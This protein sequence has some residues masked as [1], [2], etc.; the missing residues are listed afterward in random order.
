MYRWVLLCIAFLLS[1]EFAQARMRHFDFQ[2]RQSIVNPDC[3]NQSYSVPTIN[4]EFPAPVIRVVQEDVV[5]IAITNNAA[6]ATSVHFHG[7]RQYG[8]PEADG[9]ADITQLAIQP[10]Q[11]YVHRFQIRNQVG[12]YFYH[13]H[14]GL[15]DESIQGPFIVYENEESLLKAAGVHSGG[16]G[17]HRAISP[18]VSD[19]PFRYHEERILQW[20]EWWHQ[21]IEERYNYYMGKDY[22]FE[23]QADSF[24]LNGKSV[25]SNTS[26]ID[27]TCNG[28]E[29]IDVEPNKIYRLRFIGALTHRTLGIVIQNHP[30]TLIEIDGEYVQPKDID[31]VELSPGQRMSVLIKTENYPQGTI[32]PISSNIRWNDRNRGYTT[33]G[34]GY[35]R[36]GRRDQQRLFEA[37]PAELLPKVF[38]EKDI[39]G[40][41]LSQVSPLFQGDERI[42]NG[43]AA[44]TLKIAMQ[45]VVEEG[46]L[47][48]FR[49]NGRK[50]I[51][52]GTPTMSLFDIVT[53]HPLSSQSR[54][55]ADGFS[56]NHQTYPVGPL[57]IVD[58]VFQNMK[59]KDNGLCL[60]HP[61]HTHGHS[62]YLLAEGD[63]DY[64]HDTHKDV[65]TF[66]NPL[67]KDV[68]NVYPRD[69][70][71]ST[72]GCGWT[73]VRIFTVR[74]YISIFI[75]WQC[76]TFF[77][78]FLS[79]FLL[80]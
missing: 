74:I 26:V 70:G 31:Y 43:K 48:R 23:Q 5:E 6:S 57:E 56:I 4:G 36:Y 27:D 68:S 62:H 12:T 71:N 46:N 11:S 17:I 51:P 9:V 64:N 7:I 76:L 47:T 25:F 39:P 61:W 37:P 28:F 35:L 18:L 20:S 50:H 49:N 2:V 42:I 19:S 58:I 1:L 44:K 69:V 80:G 10:G 38:P 54:I 40:W 73:K 29:I 33:N 63:G 45:E 59:I 78:F 22:L 67:L 53:T 3:H 79:F 77:F 13:A 8:T 41:V 75:Y 55:E 32:F 65:R 60:I 15:Q 34:Y 14:V 30:M 52:W 21:P 72:E 24:L 66:R 16:I